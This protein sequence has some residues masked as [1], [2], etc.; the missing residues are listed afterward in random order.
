MKEFLNSV[1]RARYAK[2]RPT[3]EANLVGLRERGEDL[4][5]AVFRDVTAEDIPKLAQLH[6]VAW[7]ETYPDV[8]RPPTFAI[9]EYQWIEQF[10][11]P[12]TNWF[13]VVIELDGELI[14]FTKG[15]TYSSA[16][17]PEFTGEIN[18]IYLLSQYQRLGLGKRLVLETAERF[19]QRGIDAV[20]LFG[21]P[22]NPSIAFHEAIGGERL[23]NT[24]G[25]FDGGYGWTNLRELIE[26][27]KQ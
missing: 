1:K 21:E 15:K 25:G 12:Q 14:G 6:V 19:L 22:S 9:R 10:Q 23:L 2:L 8:K 11:S 20:V 18:K 3:K 24:K 17:R 5:K 27:L 13:A 26:R 16:E 7:A 4:S